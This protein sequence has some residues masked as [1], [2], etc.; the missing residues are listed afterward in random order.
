MQGTYNSWLVGLSILVAVLV[1]YT[2]LGLASRVAEADRSARRVWLLCGASAM[3]IGVWSMHFI[4]MLAFSLSIPLRYD[5]ST[6]L[7]SLV[8]AILTSGLALKIASGTHLSLQRLGMGALVMGAGIS[9]MHY[10]G[11]AA[12]QIVPMITYEPILVAASIVIAV[13]ASFA[14][15]WLAFHLRQQQYR[16]IRAARLAA[17]GI[18]GLAISGMHYTAMAASAF[19]PGS[20][21]RGGTLLDNEWLA[22]VVGL[23]AIALL[24]VVSITEIYDARSK[25]RS[26]LHAHRLQAAGAKLQHRGTHDGLTELPNGCCSSSMSIE[27]CKPPLK[28]AL[29]LQCSLSTWI[30]LS[31]STTRWGM[32]PATSC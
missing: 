30:A 9:G 19:G 1:S 7:V 14:A 26:R 24:A 21:C 25:V 27:R 16:V 5:I 17:A 3:G 12:I 23:S 10:L 13:V 8:V 15:L 32:L 11:M 28:R 2:A 22:L 29:G 4:G 31:A 6:T 18:M 20:Y